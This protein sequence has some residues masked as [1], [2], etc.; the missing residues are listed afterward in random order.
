MIFGRHNFVISIE[1]LLEWVIEDHF[2]RVAEYIECF[3]M[4]ITAV[5]NSFIFGIFVQAPLVHKHLFYVVVLMY[6]GSLVA[7][8]TRTFIL[9]GRFLR[10]ED[11]SEL[12][13]KQRL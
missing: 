13:K 8:F 6:F 1:P 4:L 10:L 11:G 7:Y 9:I 5:L 12:L 2:F 3:M